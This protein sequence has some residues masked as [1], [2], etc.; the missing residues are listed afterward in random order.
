[1]NRRGQLPNVPEPMRV[2]D[3]VIEK[4]RV[5]IDSRSKAFVRV[6]LN[7]LLARRRRLAQIDEGFQ[8][9][10]GTFVPA[11]SRLGRFGYIGRG[12]AGG[13]PIVVGDLTMLSTGIQIV[14]NDHGVDDVNSCMRLAFRWAHQVTIFEADAWVGHGVIIRAGVRIGYGA[15]VAAGAVVTKDVAPMSVVGGNPARLIKARFPIA[16]SKRYID[17]M[18]SDPTLTIKQ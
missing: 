6:F 16:E 17:M 1:M 18:F 2:R 14:G 7:S 8:L 4:C 13:S 15:V 9:G 5:S 12:F 11:G 3:D 10:V